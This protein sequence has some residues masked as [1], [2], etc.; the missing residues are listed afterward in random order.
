MAIFGT[1]TKYTAP[2]SGSVQIFTVNATVSTRD[3]TL[4]NTGPVAIAVGQIGVTTTTG[5]LVPPGQQL[6]LQ[7]PTENLYA[8]ASTGSVGCLVEVGLGTVVS[9]V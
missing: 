9:V 8:V 2:T 7:G 3:V 6:T 5:I 4:I 1:V